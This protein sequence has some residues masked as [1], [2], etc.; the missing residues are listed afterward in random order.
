MTIGECAEL[1]LKRY[2][3]GQVRSDNDVSEEQVAL[4]I[5]ALRNTLMGE[6]LKRTKGLKLTI[7]ES[8]FTPHTLAVSYSDDYG[9]HVTLPRG[10]MDAPDLT[11]VVV[12]PASRFIQVPESWIDEPHRLIRLEGNSAYCVDPN[13]RIRFFSNP[14]VSSIK[15]YVLENYT[16]DMDMDE[17]LRLPS[18]LEAQ[19]IEMACEILR[20]NRVFIDKENDGRDNQQ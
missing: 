10:Y 16:P 8:L 3:G 9:Y 15:V 1:V 13:G 18:E 14:L 6:E 11:T 2:Y 19:V 17:P 20:G 12:R 4:H 7:D 5:F